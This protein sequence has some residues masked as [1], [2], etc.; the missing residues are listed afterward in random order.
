MPIAA[1]RWPMFREVPRRQE[2]MDDMMKRRG[3]DL[4]DAHG[5]RAILRRGARQVS[6]EIKIFRFLS[7]VICLIW[8]VIV[9]LVTYDVVVVIFAK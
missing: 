9:L 6:L 1:S 7:L 3:G 5:Q 8:A 2:L 4:L